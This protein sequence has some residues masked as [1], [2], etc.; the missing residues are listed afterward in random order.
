MLEVKAA[1]GSVLY[2]HSGKMPQGTAVNKPGNQILAPILLTSDKF[3]VEVVRVMQDLIKIDL[4]SSFT[5]PFQNNSGPH[6]WRW[7]KGFLHRLC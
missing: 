5:G 2:S 3:T 6:L 4:A 7:L 1:S